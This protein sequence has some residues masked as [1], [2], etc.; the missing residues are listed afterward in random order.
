MA[1]KSIVVRIKAD[2]EEAHQLTDIQYIR[3]ALCGHATY[4]EQELTVSEIPAS[5]RESAR[6]I[7]FD[8]GYVKGY[9]N[10]AASEEETDAADNEK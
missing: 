5:Q 6:T 3:D 10:E 2:C 4:S 8:D 1:T 7:D 9:D